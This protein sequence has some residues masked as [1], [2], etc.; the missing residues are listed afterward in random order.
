MRIQARKDLPMR[1]D[2]LVQWTLRVMQSLQPVAPWAETFPE[3]AATL[4]QIAESS[5]L[6]PSETDGVRR[7]LALLLSV[8]NFESALKPDAEGDCDARD[9]D[10][11]GMCKKGAR[12]HSLCMFQV[13]DS[14]LKA[15][16]TNREAIL[17]DLAVCTRSALTLI[18]ISFGV[19]RSR[20]PED[21]LAQ[22]AAG[23]GS[24]GGPKGEGL[25][26]SRHRMAK[27]RWIFANQ[28]LLTGLE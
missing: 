9:R 6:Y 3:S 21:Q 23:G 28:S 1:T 5:P 18:R 25:L 19:C 15:L 17:T 24:C 14:N 4:V 2:L 13:G 27:A 22:Y 10:K 12:G 16:G 8:A 26:E 7:T 20:A 11:S